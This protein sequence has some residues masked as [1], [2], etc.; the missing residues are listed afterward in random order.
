MLVYCG[1]NQV[2]VLCRRI[3]TV[4]SDIFVCICKILGYHLP[5][6]YSIVI[7]QFYLHGSYWLSWIY[8]GGW[9]GWFL[10]KTSPLC[11]NDVGVCVCVCVAETCSSFV[12]R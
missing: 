5:A 10:G 11:F 9:V 6:S 12:R 8:L 3:R 1:F 7:V 4:K 2:Y